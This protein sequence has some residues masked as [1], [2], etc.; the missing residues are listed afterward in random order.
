[1]Y[2]FDQIQIEPISPAH[3][4]PRNNDEQPGILFNKFIVE[5]HLCWHLVVDLPHML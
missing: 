4:E 3:G 2:L 1:M 5:W